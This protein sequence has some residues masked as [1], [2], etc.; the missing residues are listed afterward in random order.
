MFE[1]THS[2]IQAFGHFF[3][4]AEDVRSINGVLAA[5]EPQQ[6]QFNDALSSQVQHTRHV[7]TT[8]DTQSRRNL[9][10]PRSKTC[11][12]HG[13]PTNAQPICLLYTKHG[14]CRFGHKCKFKH[15]HNELSATNHTECSPSFSTAESTLLPQPPTPVPTTR[16]AMPTSTLSTSSILPIASPH[17]ATREIYSQPATNRESSE[18]CRA[19]S[20]CAP[21]SYRETSKQC[22][23]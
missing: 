4:D 20:G 22:W 21:E 7:Q 16:L 9:Q 10:T 14:Q 1:P 17:N 11:A 3:Q 6:V 15:V 5:S 12:Q 8:P 13:M 19:A 2:S 23:D 18:A